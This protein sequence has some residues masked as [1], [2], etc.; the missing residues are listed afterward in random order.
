M[1]IVP[2]RFAMG[3]RIE[4]PQSAIDEAQYGPTLAAHVDR[5]KGKAPV[6]DYRLAAEVDIG[7]E[8]LS[9]SSSDGEERRGEGEAV[10]GTGPVAASA[11]EMAERDLWMREHPTVEGDRWDAVKGAVGA[12]GPSGAQLGS[13]GR[14]MGAGVGDVTRK[15]ARDDTR[16]SD[17][18]TGSRS[19]GTVGVDD[20]LGGAEAGGRERQGGFGDSE[21]RR[22]N[23]YSFCMC[24]GGQVVPT[25]TSEMHL[26]V[27]GM[28]FS[29]RNSRWANSALVVGV[30][31]ED[32]APYEGQH[33]VLAGLRL[34]VR[35]EGGVAG[36]GAVMR[37]CAPRDLYGFHAMASL[38]KGMRIVLAL[39]GGDGE[40]GGDDGRWE[41]PGASAE[42]DGLRQRQAL[43]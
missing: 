37:G 40:K 16:G 22:R 12:E 15:V 41:V 13:D 31:P 35:V 36:A 21:W 14:P 24:P 26:C 17:E 33:G 11:E 4:H 8:G 34:Q 39:T 10:G 42:S 43:R 30:V 28:S 20:T 19:D 9:G 7:G 2:K 23:V 3:F 27:N 25:S 32:W 1:E 18:A 29:R 38:M 6:A 5:G